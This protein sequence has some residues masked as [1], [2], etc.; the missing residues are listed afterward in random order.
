[1]SLMS[2][3]A[4]RVTED[5]TV[6]QVNFTAT[7]HDSAVAVTIVVCQLIRQTDTGDLPAYTYLI[8]T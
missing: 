2:V 4:I 3:F 8:Q 1:M 6:K 7:T 5:Q